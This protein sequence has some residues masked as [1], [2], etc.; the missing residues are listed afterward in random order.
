MLLPLVVTVD[1]VVV[2]VL[3]V[4]PPLFNVMPLLAITPL[5]GLV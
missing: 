2:A 1:A 3:F 5:L 4:R